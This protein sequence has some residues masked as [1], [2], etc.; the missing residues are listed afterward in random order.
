MHVHPTPRRYGAVNWLGLWSLI[1]KDVRRGLKEYRYSVLGPVV[2]NL[3]F[4]TVFALA[5]SHEGSYVGNLTFIQ[6]LVP[7]LI[8]FAA[9]ERA[10]GTSSESV[11]FDKMEGMIAD[12]LMAPLTAIERTVGYACSSA[13]MGL[14]TGA[15]TAVP[16]LLLVDLPVASLPLACVFAVAGTLM[17]GL[18]GVI[19]GL[20]AERWDHY[21]AALTFLVIPF[22]F[23]S[24][25]FYSIAALPEIGA[26]AARLNPMFYVID[27]F[28]AGS[29]GHADGSPLTG[30][31]VLLLVVTALGVVTHRLFR[32]GY[33][34]KP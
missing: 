10:Y 30:I 21:T 31:V 13:A 11:L 28:R 23:L 24:G 20:W 15:A 26:Q 25:T 4:L 16:M 33:K 1:A 14:V 2:S 18:F 22:G 17:H 27:G 32:I 8:I 9:C 7:G 12:T 5:R 29:T 19:V 3:L 6:F 34:I